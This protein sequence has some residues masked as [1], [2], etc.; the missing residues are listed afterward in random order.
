MMWPVLVSKTCKMSEASGN[1]LKGRKQNKSD[2]ILKCENCNKNVRG[3]QKVSCKCNLCV[4][5]SEGC[6][7]SNSH[8]KI[9][10]GGDASRLDSLTR[11]K[12]INQVNTSLA[13]K[14]KRE[15][16]AGLETI[17]FNTFE[18]LKAKEE[19]PTACWRVAVALIN[20]ESQA[21]GPY[22]CVLPSKYSK[23]SYLERHVRG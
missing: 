10:R 13:E 11:A 14:L 2:P 17:A 18:E 6:K 20:N 7:Q 16:D 1:N 3:K 23:L 22:F 15:V 9:C 21:R 12:L 5:C 8:F 19:N 4:F